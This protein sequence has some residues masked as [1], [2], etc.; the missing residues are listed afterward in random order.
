MLYAPA[1]ARARRV[2]RDP[3]YRRRQCLSTTARSS[4]ARTRSARFSD[5]ATRAQAAKRAAVQFAWDRYQAAGD[6]RRD[7]RLQENRGRMVSMTMENASRRLNAGV[8]LHGV[9]LYPFVDVPDWWTQQWRRS[10]STMSPTRGVSTGPVR[11]PT[12]RA[13]PLAE[14]ARPPENVEPDGYGPPLGPGQLAEVRKYASSR[15]ARTVPSS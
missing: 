5:R 1:C 10:A 8:E 11:S 4:W 2:A 14:A 6:H 7:Q 15:E 9:C 12:S 3:R 13:A